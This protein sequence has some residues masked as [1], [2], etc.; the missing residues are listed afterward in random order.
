MDRMFPAAAAMKRRRI[1][2]Q[3]EEGREAGTGATA[4]EPKAAP[5]KPPEASS[6][7]H[8]TRRSKKEIDV[9]AVAREHREAEDEAATRDEELMRAANDGVGV[10]EMRNLAVIEEMP[11]RAR[12]DRRPAHA[13]M[14]EVGDQARWDDRWNGRKNFKKFRRRG[15]A[16]QIQ[17]HQST[18]I[19][20]GLE[21]V[22]GRGLGFG[23]EAF[24]G[25]EKEKRH[26]ENRPSDTRP[27]TRP[28]TA[29]N[30]SL[31]SETSFDDVMEVTAPKAAAMA[32]TN[33]AE[34]TN[35]NV[36]PPALPPNEEVPSSISRTAPGKRP[37]SRSVIRSTPPKKQKMQT[38][39]FERNTKDGGGGGSGS[40]SDEEDELRF[41]F[42]RRQ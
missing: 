9:L 16:A 3:E 6:H 21:E 15:N 37:V 23:N 8:G 4:Q 5:L 17:S 32:T 26:K 30:G 11:V 25:R 40:S 42:N 24:I 2:E 28:P 36:I 1:A 20:V 7:M 33:H 34:T 35:T 14:S 19:I 29:R 12:S 18:S 22:K 41:R 31:P 27:S 13:G 38:K 39:L 10:E